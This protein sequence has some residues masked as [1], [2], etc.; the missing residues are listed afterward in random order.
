M[1]HRKVA[2]KQK[3]AE[4]A[5]YRPREDIGGEHS[6]N[7]FEETKE[8]KW[9]RGSCHWPDELQLLFSKASFKQDA[10]W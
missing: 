6:T 7:V 1:S 10:S 5:C 2:R 9:M 4:V 3:L 8:K